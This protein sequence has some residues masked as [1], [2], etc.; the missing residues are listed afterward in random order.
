M[1]IICKSCKLNSDFYLIVFKRLYPIPKISADKRLS[2]SD[3]VG[4]SMS[5]SACKKLLLP[6]LFSPT[7]TMFA[8]NKPRRA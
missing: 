8:L 3:M 7:K 2:E 5:L 1:W 4:S 6:A